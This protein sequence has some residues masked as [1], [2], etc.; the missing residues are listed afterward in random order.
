M[1]AL[2]E[3]WFIE[4]CEEW[5]VPYI[6]DLLAVRDLNVASPRSFG[7]ERRAYVANTLFYRQRKGT[8]PVL[9]QLARD[10][11]GWGARAVESLQLVATTQ[12]IND[13]RSQSQTILLRPPRVTDAIAPALAREALPAGYR[14]ATPFE[15]AVAYTTQIRPNRGDR[16]RY[17]PASVALYLWQLQTYQIENSTPRAVSPEGVQ[18]YCFT[19][20]PLGYSQPLFNLP[21][22]ETELTTLAQEENVPGILTGKLLQKLFAQNNPDRLP[23]QVWVNNQPQPFEVVDLS[24]WRS[25]APLAIDPERG[26]LKFQTDEPPQNLAVSYVEG[27]S[28]DIGAGAYERFDTIFTQPPVP[29]QITYRVNSV[30]ELASAAKTWN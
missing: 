25:T 2:Y 11:T 14:L 29:G 18:R 13:L 23:V 4:T 7:Q 5:V 30:D 10:I 9:E 6:G 3:N 15:T 19:F 1:E 17:N 24:E 20:N 28:G 21:Q 12:N 26:H 8:T 27:F 16:V 22:T